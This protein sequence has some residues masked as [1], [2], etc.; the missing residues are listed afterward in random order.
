MFLSSDYMSE[1]IFM[2]RV[3]FLLVCLALFLIIKPIR[4]S[5]PYA[6]LPYS[7]AYNF[8][9]PVSISFFRKYGYLLGCCLCLQIVTGLFFVFGYTLD[10]EIAFESLT[11]IICDV[12]FECLIRSL[13]VNR[14]CFFLACLYVHLVRGDYKS[15]F[16]SY[17]LVK[18]LLGGF[19]VFRILLLG[20]ES[21]L[22]GI[23]LWACYGFF[24][25]WSVF[26]LLLFF[27]SLFSLIVVSILGWGYDF[28]QRK[29]GASIML[30]MVSSFVG[31]S[32]LFFFNWKISIVFYRITFF[33]I[34]VAVALIINVYWKEVIVIMDCFLTLIPVPLLCYLL[35]YS[36]FL[37]IGVGSDLLVSG[38]IWWD[39]FSFLPTVHCAGG[40][41]DPII[42]LPIPASK[43]M[44]P[45]PFVPGGY[46]PCPYHGNCWKCLMCP[47]TVERFCRINSGFL[48]T[49]GNPVVA[50]DLTIQ[51]FFWEDCAKT[52]IHGLIDEWAQECVW[53]YRRRMTN[54]QFNTITTDPMVRVE[55]IHAHIKEWRK[56]SNL[57][58][59]G[60]PIIDDKIYFY[61]TMNDK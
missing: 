16:A 26:S 24:V 47:R 11:Y 2:R 33:I 37:L 22:R 9:D 25:L 28:D 52:K 30:S 36:G 42:A 51:R 38:L 35:C 57:A 23:I 31:F 5:D 34:C 21:L 58:E 49:S 43:V 32:F 12:N 20:V 18:D 55:H 7:V 45:S 46:R 61:G 40:D 53:D 8:P 3:L 41:A 56:A 14:V 27:V 50:Y 19:I 54:D 10:V 13:Y 17:L 29:L 1:V 4:K 15:H 44:C 60:I 39:N 6:N 48:A 59:F